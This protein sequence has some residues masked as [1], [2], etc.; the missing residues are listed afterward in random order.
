[1]SLFHD[2][3]PILKKRELRFLE[4]VE[5]SKGIYTFVFAKGADLA[6]K[7][8]QHGVFS[9]SHKKIKKPARP[10][11]IASAPSENT[12]IISMAIGESPSEFKKA[13]LELEPGMVLKMRG[14]I[15]SLYLKD[16]GPSLLIAGG[17]GITPFRSMLIEEKGKQG[18]SVKLL[19]VDTKG[20]FIYK[21]ELDRL[22]ADSVMELEYISSREELYPHL[23]QS[24]S[25]WSNS[26]NYYI[27]GPKA[28]A[29]DVSRHL[30][31]N[32]IVKGNIH[33]DIFWGY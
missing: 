23:D 9:I 32:G 33:K 5:E 6:W 7:A 13:M 8:G 30:K 15:G 20:A 1:M 19:Y 27:A 18:M 2:L 3:A 26:G 11:S 29:D 10:F 21:Q 12:V 4:R 31:A 25:T 24:V 17:I 16:N 28:L 14:P 22:A